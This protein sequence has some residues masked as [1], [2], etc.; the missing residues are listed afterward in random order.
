[1]LPLLP[2]WCF[3]I[4]PTVECWRSL[5]KPWKTAFGR[6]QRS[7]LLAWPERLPQAKELKYLGMLFTSDG[8][9]WACG[10]DASWVPPFGGFPGIPNWKETLRQTHNRLERLHVIWPEDAS[11]FPKKNQKVRL[12]SW[13]A[14]I[15][16]LACCHCNLTLI[17]WRI[18]N[19]AFKRGRTKY[20]NSKNIL[21]I[22]DQRFYF[23]SL[24]AL[25]GAHTGQVK[26]ERAICVKWPV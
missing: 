23:H 15:V 17:K 4:S 25:I 10:Y 9:V 6:C 18:I 22:K 5:E 16:S 8:K 7:S 26:K 11:G 24:H 14:G 19:R 2:S 12:E 3:Q 13:I 20:E 1:M 21:Y